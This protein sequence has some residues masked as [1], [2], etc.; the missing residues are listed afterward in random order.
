MINY[1][2]TVTVGGEE[3]TSSLIPVPAHQLE[4]IDRTVASRPQE[5]PERGDVLISSLLDQIKKDEWLNLGRCGNSSSTFYGI[6]VKYI[7]SIRVEI[8]EEEEA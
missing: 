4:E 2:V 6:Q 5:F 1:F 7:Q 8:V 3:H